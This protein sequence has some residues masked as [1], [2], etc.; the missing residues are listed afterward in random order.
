[1][2]P[3][4]IEYVY[5]VAFQKW[6]VVNALK[7]LYPGFNVKAYLMMAD[8]DQV[9]SVDGMNQCFRIVKDKNNRTKVERTDDSVNLKIRIRIFIC[10]STVRAEV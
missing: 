3:S 8:K 4:I 6:V 2:A 9:A 1:M 5:D 10:I 7:E